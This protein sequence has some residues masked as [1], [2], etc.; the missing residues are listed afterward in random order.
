[1]PKYTFEGVL[2]PMRQ[3]FPLSLNVDQLMA[4]FCLATD[5]GEY[6]P[7]RETVAVGEPAVDRP[8]DSEDGRRRGGEGPALKCLRERRRRACLVTQ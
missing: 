8:A 7:R 6:F 4:L 2:R 1:M 5:R 3:K